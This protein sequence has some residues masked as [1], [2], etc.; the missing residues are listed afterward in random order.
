[1]YLVSQNKERWG[2][3]LHNFFTSFVPVRFMRKKKLSKVWLSLT[4]SI[5]MLLFMGNI[6]SATTSDCTVMIDKHNLTLTVGEVGR[7]ADVLTVVE[8]T[9][10]YASIMWESSDPSVAAVTSYGDVIAVGE[11]VA[12][13]Y[14]I[15]NYGKDAPAADQ[16]KVTVKG[17]QQ[18]VVL[19]SLRLD[20]SS[21]QLNIGDTI[22][23][24]AVITPYTIDAS[25]IVWS[26]SD[27]GV[28]TVQN[29]VIRAVSGGTAVITA[30]LMG[31]TASCTVDVAGAGLTLN[32]SDLVLSGPGKGE[33]LIAELK[34][35]NAVDKT[36]TWTTTNPQ[37]AWVDETGYVTAVSDGVAIITA[38]AGNH[39]ADC[40]VQV[41]T[42]IEV[43]WVSLMFSRLDI[44]VGG[45][46]MLYAS[47][48]PKGAISS[49]F[50]WTSSDPSV[51]TVDSNGRVTGLKEGLA[52]VRVESD[53]IMVNKPAM[54]TV[55]E[56]SEEDIE[57][58]EIY[59][60]QIQ[61][62][63]DRKIDQFKTL[64]DLKIG[65]VIDFG[66]RPIPIRADIPDALLPIRWESS[67]PAVATVDP[68]GNK[69]AKVTILSN[70]TTAITATTA[71]GLYE[72]GIGYLTVEESILPPVVDQY[73]QTLC[74][75][76]Q[77]LLR[78]DSFKVKIPTHTAGVRG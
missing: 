24:N 20:P 63:H 18:A 65:E 50:T 33:T 76:V 19:E 15:N 29:G 55:T 22:V 28:A 25:D 1:M 4:L 32:K 64:G 62:Y 74:E 51:A 30:S 40:R 3:P 78:G 44:E 34:P 38:R 56:K 46:G 21:V 17:R 11:G 66:V 72:S 9:P 73:L 2:E 60:Q 27:S 48:N 77:Y 61:I 58:E 35:A 69:W 49:G 59:L 37:V 41:E 43:E 12:T 5:V 70:G 68:A 45:S 42:V 7:E 54:I 57:E 8:K 10:K 71:N 47:V 67:N 75:N 39:T 13:I 14:A 52:F 16:C 53:G 36:I 6:V 23:P 31:K 26:S